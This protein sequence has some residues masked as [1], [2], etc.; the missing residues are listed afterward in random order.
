M[1]KDLLHQGLAIFLPEK[2]IF[3]GYLASALVLAFFSYTNFRRLAENDRPDLGAGF[4]SFVFDPKVYGHRSARQDYL[5]FL[6]NAVIYYGIVAHF[7]VGQQVFASVSERLITAFAGTLGTP[8]LGSSLSIALY[9]LGATLTMDFGAYITHYLQHKNPVLWHFHKVHHSAEV[10]TPITLYRIHPLDLA[11]TGLAI[12]A[13]G[14]TVLGLFSYLSGMKPEVFTVFGVNV[15]VFL[16]YVFGYNLRHS[17]I[18]LAYPRWLSHILVS[19]AQHQ[20]H[21]S[22]DPK[23]RDRNLG[24]VFAFW[25]WLFGTLYVPDGYEKIEYGVST[26]ERNPFNSVWELY[27]LPFRWAGQTIKADKPAKEGLVA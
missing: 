12:A 1:I 23:H 25:D 13:L 4:F 7:L 6:V 9:T 27:V 5:F 8:V 18:W 22:A 20:I 14:G 17:H 16:F 24:L 19:P 26:K 2:R 21:H 15:I 10:L 11:V 3:I